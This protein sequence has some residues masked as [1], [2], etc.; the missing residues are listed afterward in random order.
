MIPAALLPQYNR[1][2]VDAPGRPPHIDLLAD[3]ITFR[4][5][6]TWLHGDRRGSIDR[7]HNTPGT[8]LLPLMPSREA[9][10]LKF[11][12]F[13]LNAAQRRA[14]EEA[15]RARCQ[16]KDREPHAIVT[17]DGWAPEEVMRTLKAW[18]TRRLRE[19]GLS[20]RTEPVWSHHG[21]TIYLWTSEQLASAVWYAVE[22]QERPGSDWP[23]LR[24]QR[25]QY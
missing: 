2:G 20:L 1:A 9:R 6:G 21:S 4:C 11:P 3:F 18:A 15:L 23:A 8:P 25:R 12:P 13:T 22:A 17:A 24:S 16:H 14:V 10:T 19:A 7:K 5:Y